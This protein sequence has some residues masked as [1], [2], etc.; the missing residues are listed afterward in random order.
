MVLPVMEADK[1]CDEQGSCVQMCVGAD[2]FHHGFA[3]QILCND[4]FKKEKGIKV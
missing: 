2:T 4:T 3:L 1:Q